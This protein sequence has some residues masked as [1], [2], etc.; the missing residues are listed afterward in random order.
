MRLM[1][2]EPF[3][4]IVRL[5]RIHCRAEICKQPIQVY[6]PFVAGGADEK[7]FRVVKDR[8]RWFQIVM[9]QKT[10]FDEHTTEAISRRVPIPQRL[11]AAV[12]FNLA[13]WASDGR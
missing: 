8:E 2:R 3:F 7:M 4:G 6:E 13:R 5:D 1:F 12:T 9:G 10:A 11:V